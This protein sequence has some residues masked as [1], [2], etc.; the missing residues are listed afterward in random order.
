MRRRA[1]VI[2]AGCIAALVW[3]ATA[4][5][6]PPERFHS[7]DSGS[8]PGFVHCDGFDIDLATTSAESF[9]VYFDGSGEVV[10]VLVRIRARD[11]FTNSVTG[12]TVVNRGV[13][14]ELFV[15]V[16]DTDEFTHSL[17][18]YRFMATDPGRGVVIQDVGRIEFVGQQEDIVFLAG[19]HHVPDDE[20]AEEVFCAA[21]SG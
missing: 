18:G 12:K 6:A 3:A 13:F 16:G 8:E 19:Q 7:D 5:A 17:T 1:T 15:R 2:T 10:K 14:Q 4:L 20:N 9:T 11:V 21:L